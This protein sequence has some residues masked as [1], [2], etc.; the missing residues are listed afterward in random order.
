MNN[1]NIQDI[2]QVILFTL[3]DDVYGID[4]MDTAEVLIAQE[5]VRVPG[6]PPV[7]EGTFTLRGETIRIYNLKKLIGIPYFDLAKEKSIIALKLKHENETIGLLVDRVLKVE[8][9][10]KEKLECIPRTDMDCLIHCRKTITEEAYMRTEEEI[11][12]Y[13][14]INPNCLTAEI[15]KVKENGLDTSESRN[16]ELMFRVPEVVIYKLATDRLLTKEERNLIEELVV[17]EFNVKNEVLLHGTYRYLSKLA[18][19][20][21]KSFTSGSIEEVKE[22]VQTKIQDRKRHELP[23]PY[24]TIISPFNYLKE[25]ALL[26]PILTFEAIRYIIKEYGKPYVSVIERIEKSKQAKKEEE[27]FMFS[28]IKSHE[29]ES[30]EDEELYDKLGHIVVATP[31]N[32]EDLASVLILLNNIYRKTGLLDILETRSTRTP[33]FVWWYPLGSKLKIMDLSF[34]EKELRYI[35]PSERQTYFEEAYT[36]SP[37]VKELFSNPISQKE[38]KKYITRDEIITD[39]FIEAPEAFQIKEGIAEELITKGISHQALQSNIKEIARSSTFTEETTETGDKIYKLR[40]QYHYLAQKPLIRS[41]LDNIFTPRGIE[42]YYQSITSQEA[43]GML[44]L[45][46]D[47]NYLI[48]GTLTATEA[49]NLFGD[50]AEE[51]TNKVEGKYKLKEEYRRS[52]KGMLVHDNLE[53]FEGKV[54]IVIARYAFLV[55]ESKV[56]TVFQNLRKL[57]KKGGVL[58]LS[59]VE[60]LKPITGAFDILSLL[61]QYYYVKAKEEE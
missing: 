54:D 1:F 60:S 3:D 47:R 2:E 20:Y 23:Y 10:D 25:P 57:I 27:T 4:I 12:N 5:A 16:I 9:L 32:G 22:Y 21:S 39:Y 45:R 58:F 49:K 18:V 24:H 61:L 48:G 37:E 51:L 53:K 30:K 56:L 6:T 59:E 29:E 43:E 15:D 41:E 35:K 31:D 46:T 34:S 8:H 13:F 38:I 33:F 36:L 42:T 11:E 50:K 55:S 17:S 19:I 7:L 44:I 14:I 26:E 28:F 40:P 52:Y